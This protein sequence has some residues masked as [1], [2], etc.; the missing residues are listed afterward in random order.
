MSR[1]LTMKKTTFLL[2]SFFLV[3]GGT[4]LIMGEEP[5]PSKPENPAESTVREVPLF[6]AMDAKLIDVTLKQRNSL[7]G[8]VTVKN[9][10]GEHLRVKLPPAFAGVP[11]VAQFGDFMDFDGGGGGGRGGRGG[12]GGSGGGSS[13]GGG[14]GNQ[15]SGG[16]FGGG[17]SRGGGGGSWNLEP[18]K[19]LRQKVHTV[20]L[21]HG[22]KEPRATVKY[23][24]RPIEEVTDSK[25]VQ[26]LCNLVG[27]GK[28]DQQAIQAAVWHLNNDISWDQLAAK[29]Y[30]PRID[31]PRV[32]PYFSDRQMNMATDLVKTAKKVVEAGEDKVSPENYVSEGL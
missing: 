32:V 9:L 2:V 4:G 23:V 17:G 8:Q 10:S 7:E 13:R 18:D 11:A 16:G 12:R 28:V 3:L 24:M 19:V 25:E 5:T 21:E 27:T 31:V 26:I 22:K 1:R 30:K 15:S 20:C 6:E 14:G 29:T